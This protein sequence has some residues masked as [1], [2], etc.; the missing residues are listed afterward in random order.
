MRKLPDQLKA[1]LDA[2]PGWEEER[3]QLM[4]ELGAARASLEIYRELLHDLHQ[5]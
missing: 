4:Y 1:K 3:S 5:P 2:V